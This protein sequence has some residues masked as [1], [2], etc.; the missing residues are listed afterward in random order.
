[1]CYFRVGDVLLSISDTPLDG[2]ALEVVQDMIKNCPRGDVRVVAQAGPK[3][4]VQETDNSMPLCATERGRREE[5]SFSMS[6]PGENHEP[7]GP[8]PRT[9]VDLPEDLMSQGNSDIASKTLKNVLMSNGLQ[10]SISSTPPRQRRPDA[11]KECE[12]V[13][14]NIRL[15]DSDFGDLPPL[16]APPPVPT[17]DWQLESSAVPVGDLVVQ[18]T[19]QEISLN[20]PSIFDDFFDNSPTDPSALVCESEM[21]NTAPS[22]TPVDS[23][24]DDHSN[25]Q[26]KVES[27]N[28]ADESSSVQYKPA[29]PS[30][31][32]QAQQ[33]I[34][35]PSLFGDDTESLS[36]SPAKP[37]VDLFDQ[38]AAS[39]NGMKTVPLKPPSL[40]D[41]DLESLPSLPLPPPPPKPDKQSTGNYG[42]DTSST[43]SSSPLQSPWLKQK[44]PN[45]TA[46]FRPSNVTATSRSEPRSSS[47]SSHGNISTLE[48]FDPF[49]G[50]P[51]EPSDVP[52][53]DM[54]SLP[55]APP[56]PQLPVNRS[57]SQS[58]RSS[59]TET[60]L[61]HEQ[62]NTP[63]INRPLPPPAK[64]E[65]KNSKKRLL[66]LRITSKK[67]RKTSEQINASPENDHR[68]ESLPSSG[69]TRFD[70]YSRS[71]A[72]VEP[73]EDD[74]ESLPPAPPPPRMSPLTVES[75]ENIV[76]GYQP[77]KVAQLIPN[78]FE[79]QRATL[80]TGGDTSQSSQSP[81]KKKKS[82]RKNVIQQDVKESFSE[83]SSQSTSFPLV[84]ETN[85]PVATSG[86]QQSPP[87]DEIAVTDSSDAMSPPPLPPEMELWAETG[88]AEAE[89]ALLDQILNL[90][91]SSR[92]GNEHSSEGGSTP[93]SKRAAFPK[94]AL[95][96][97]VTEIEDIPVVS[98]SEE[99]SDRS[100]LFQGSSESRNVASRH[101]PPDMNTGIQL[102]LPSMDSHF[103]IETTRTNDDSES[104]P[105][106]VD[107]NMS[108]TS[109][110]AHQ[111]SPGRLLKQPS[112]DRD[113]GNVVKQRRPAP[114]I[115]TRPQGN[116]KAGSI[117]RKPLPAGLGVAVLPSR[118]PDMKHK[119]LPPSDQQSP[120][121]Q[122]EQKVL[123]LGREKKK[124][125]SKGHKSK[126]KQVDSNYLDSPDNSSEVN[127]EGRE[128][129]RSWTKK[130]FGFRSRS[131]SR[132]KTK[133]RDDKSRRADRSRSVSPSRGLFSRS[134]RSSSPPPPPPST[135]K[136]PMSKRGKD[137]EQKASDR[138]QREHYMAA[139][140]NTQ[141]P[142]HPATVS[143][144][145]EPF[146]EGNNN[147]PDPQVE[148]DFISALESNVVNA[149]SHLYDEASGVQVQYDYEEAQV[150]NVH[151]AQEMN[152]LIDSK[153]RSSGLSKEYDVAKEPNM[154]SRMETSR[155][156]R[157]LPVP[158]TRAEA[159]AITSYVTAKEQGAVEYEAPQKPATKPPVPK[160][161]LFLKSSSSPSRQQQRT[162]DELKRKFN[163]ASTCDE[164]PETAPENVEKLT[165]TSQDDGVQV[166]FSDHEDLPSPGPPTFKP[167][168]PPMALQADVNQN[169][170]ED[171][172][173]PVCPNSPGPPRFKPLPP[174]LALKESGVQNGVN[175]HE[176]TDVLDSPGPP[177]FKPEPPPLLLR[178]ENNDFEQ[179]DRPSLPDQPHFRPLPP[180]PIASSKMQRHE[181][182]QCV[183]PKQNLVEDVPVENQDLLD[184]EQRRTKPLPPI[185]T[186]FNLKTSAST[187]T[188][189][190]DDADN[191]SDYKLP[192]SRQ[193]AQEYDNIEDS[194]T[195]TLQHR[196]ILDST[197][198]NHYSQ[199][200][201]DVT[202]PLI[203]QNEIV[204][205]NTS[206]SDD[207]E[208]SDL[209]SEWDDTCS[210]TQDDH[211]F[212]A[213]GARF[214]RS[215]SFSAGDVQAKQPPPAGAFAGAEDQK[216]LPPVILK[217]PPPPMRRRS[218]S[219]PHLFA[220]SD[221]SQAESGSMDYWH[222]GNLQE[223]INS[224][225]QE[226]DVDEGIIEVQVRQERLRY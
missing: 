58:S 2:V 107:S 23:Q 199:V 40:F 43:N 48:V 45:V 7:N 16:I 49:G 100:K 54:A 64:P 81:K 223:L 39:W 105:V 193:D 205:V 98:K 121:H 110:I 134:R 142:V 93:A 29:M 119:T 60:S 153:R 88:S 41:D 168:L 184:V 57:S 218:S 211:G 216:R 226:P 191:Y 194:K 210:S 172:G 208:S 195:E 30:E 182:D 47:P 122:K 28:T 126:Q 77:V 106:F 13:L 55:P 145:T 3:P 91:D 90:E 65:R 207:F 80:S 117:S 42:L 99:T 71:S 157:P 155:I 59:N 56:P 5:L 11:T 202:E 176:T 188:C 174:P 79:E 131:K 173:I 224:R 32:A 167:I 82:F 96:K 33:P 162:V 175:G 123:S 26:L 103:Q 38:D 34:R 6:R 19:A 197:E 198:R 20:P 67:G 146:V 136:V 76:D 151:L 221:A 164:R 108:R 141:I 53:D 180:L 200:S 14:E 128:R 185:P 190:D 10:G 140:E 37:T 21:D 179:E 144:S 15:E 178:S 97:E 24:P 17:N 78:Q 209:S 196:T 95:D 22:L 130:L 160:K 125:F 44:I 177:Q 169:E 9:R 201:E 72:R 138:E 113:S 74:M 112:E 189:V 36:S 27:F 52:D 50:V 220:E 124:L 181:E 68:H 51:S 18:D 69:H 114:P 66:P 204:P 84:P 171:R 219:L 102:D 73:P 170:L 129:S 86:Q 203:L 35:P 156:D 61:T 75:L 206:H 104:L 215:A 1:M 92:S 115:P 116:N 183:A 192:L 62:Q 166:A 4:A 152:E 83:S 89:L 161:P 214:I 46:W 132:D 165:F 148:E 8:F 31:T 213:P 147:K 63:Q 212:Q 225:N 159:T 25:L 127:T 186:G 94:D 137:I 149:E 111:G 163:K 150:E 135:K 12:P 154:L 133:E 87:E 85:A 158:P 118:P 109:E 217:R 143:S 70:D 120:K 101:R 187:D 222:T 139:S